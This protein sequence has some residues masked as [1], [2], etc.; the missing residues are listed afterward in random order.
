M[1]KM[2]YSRVACF[3]GRKGCDSDHDG[4]T[5]HSVMAAVTV[6]TLLDETE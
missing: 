1:V 6:D 5:S 2:G 3:L 4:R